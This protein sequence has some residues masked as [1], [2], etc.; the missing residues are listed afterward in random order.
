MTLELEK[1]QI[2]F[3]IP[4]RETTE[5]APS[6]APQTNIRP[7]SWGAQQIELT[8]QKNKKHWYQKYH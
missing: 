5:T 7:Y 6:D 3:L 1:K 8:I 2:L 4:M